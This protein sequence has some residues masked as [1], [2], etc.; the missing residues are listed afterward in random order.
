MIVST[1][2]GMR[3]LVVSLGFLAT[4]TIGAHGLLAQAANP[5]TNCA[6]APG[7]CVTLTLN[8]T[9]QLTK[10]HPDVGF[11]A[12]ECKTSPMALPVQG[13]GPSTQAS[14]AQM[15][16][17][18]RSYT[19]PVTVVIRLPKWLLANPANRTTMAFCELYL[20][21]R[22]G[23]RMRARASAA[24]PEG[25]TP[26]NWDVLAVGSTVMTSPQSVTFANA[27]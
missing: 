6:A 15:P 22:A 18:N 10:L 24:V 11:V 1:C 9:L 12:V 4:S 5:A 21:D 7:D 26:S 14:S 20:S 13:P 16:V 2:D 19:G 27:P 17:T 8:G 25:I 23:A 3:R